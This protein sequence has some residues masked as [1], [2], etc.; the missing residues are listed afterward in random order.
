MDLEIPPNP[1]GSSSQAFVLKQPTLSWS[2]RTENDELR[3][4]VSQLEILCNQLKLQ[5]ET[6]SS[7]N[8]RL[9]SRLTDDNHKPEKLLEKVNEIVYVTDEEELNRETGSIRAKNKRKRKAKS[10]PAQKSPKKG[11]PVHQNRVDKSL[12]L[13]VLKITDASKVETTSDATKGETAA[14]ERI[15]LPPP[16]MLNDVKDLKLLRSKLAAS[17]K[18]GFVIKLLNNGVCKVSTHNSDDY[19]ATTKMLKDEKFSWYSYEDKSSRPIK[20]IVKNLHH[21]FDKASIV[22]DLLEQGFKSIDAINKCSWKT[23]E[24]LD[25]FL[26]VFDSTEDI[27]KIFQIKSILNTI[28]KIE[29]VKSSKLIV[30]CKNCQLF[31]HTKNFCGKTARCV[32]C[33]GKHATSDCTKTVDEPPKCCN[34]GMGHPANYRGCMVAKELQK[35]KDAKSKPNRPSPTPASIEDL[36]KG[37]SSS[38]TAKIQQP[39]KYSNPGVSYA[40]AASAA[41][42]ENSLALILGKLDKQAKMFKTLEQRLLNLEAQMQ[43]YD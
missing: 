37:N 36:N 15:R 40:D 23:K 17:S 14:T 38:S 39:V 19:R 20:V 2:T 10:P 18:G 31:G 7:E 32:K 22:G 12:A 21:S 8:E 9:K 35:I 33:L 34:C 28:V 3:E 13:E 6:L 27:S 43:F 30:Q 5:L 29:P 26:L 16:I 41:T 11:Q 25:I 1:G 24:P 42:N 4:K